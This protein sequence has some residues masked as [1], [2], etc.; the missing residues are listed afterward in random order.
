MNEII[1]T[2]PHSKSTDCVENVIVQKT[3]GQF[4]RF[5]DYLHDESKYQGNLPALIAFPQDVLE[6]SALLKFAENRGLSVA[7]SGARTGLGGGAVPDQSQLLISTEKLCGID[8]C[9]IAE[10]RATAKVRVGTT[11]SAL[12]EYLSI[13]APSWFFP[14]NPT[15]ST[16]SL[17][18]MIATNASG[19][20]SFRYGSMRDWVVGL[21]CIL[22]SGA[23]LKVV[24]GQYR[25]HGGKFVL[26][27]DKTTRVLQATNIEKPCTKHSI[28]YSYEEEVDL[29]DVLVGSEGTL[30]FV[31]S[32]E[33]RLESQPLH[34][35]GHLQFF[36]EEQKALQ[37]VKILRKDSRILASEIEFLDARS[38]QLALQSN[39][40]SLAVHEDVSGM[41]AVFVEY[42]IYQDEEIDILYEYLQ[43]IWEEL[44]I[45][46]DYSITAF[47]DASHRQ[48]KA[49]RHAVPEM[50]NAA[51]VQVKQKYPLVHKIATDMAVPDEFLEHIYQFYKEGLDNLGLEY[52]IWGHIA[53]NHFHVN[54]LPRNEHEL[55]T[56][57]ELYVSFA[58]EVI[59]LGGAVSAE[60]GI[61]RLKK[62]FLRMQYSDKVIAQ[63]KAIKLFFDPD[64]RLNPGVLF[65]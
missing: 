45:V 42:P 8:G 38:I 3:L 44:G 28:G 23:V 13:F 21:E 52:A 57:K 19:A 39:S 25:A 47:D 55:V 36:A 20:R 32:V 17:G 43:P 56:A 46:D 24:R 65:D 49:F 7:L 6:V 63:M 15:E 29:I 34:W 9:T 1:A 18:G 33:L 5:R 60:H 53:N 54:V 27:D 11:L 62:P 30:A 26:R 22:A 2:V 10:D 16:A 58:K 37:Y 35:I 64:Y 14:I 48:I 61:G 31:S 50:V 51:I 12:N 59:G 40:H 4:D 41:T